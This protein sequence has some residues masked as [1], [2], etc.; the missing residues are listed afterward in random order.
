MSLQ[1]IAKMPPIHEDADSIFTDVGPASRRRSTR[2][3]GF[4]QYG[5]DYITTY[6]DLGGL[7]S[8]Q[9]P[10]RPGSVVSVRSA[11][12]VSPGSISDGS[13]AGAGGSG[14]FLNPNTT[15]NPRRASSRLSVGSVSASGISKAS[16][17]AS[18]STTVIG[19]L[20]EDEKD[21]RMSLNYA[22]IPEA[23]TSAAAS[24]SFSAMTD[25][26]ASSDLGERGLKE[27][28]VD[29]GDVVKSRGCFRRWLRT[30]VLLIVILIVAGFAV[31]LAFGLKNR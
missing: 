25:R 3:G 28:S 12:S 22:S 1:S 27:G 7:P 29:D 23:T 18:T 19:S 30:I 20:S 8:P 5:E 21:R 14:Y 16:R 13:V 31:G 17:Q 15:P 24:S 9:P 4:Y 2:S 11:R 6:D 10:Q 26:G